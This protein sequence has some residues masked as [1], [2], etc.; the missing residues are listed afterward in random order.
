MRRF[1]FTPRRSARP[2]V[3]PFT[4]FVALAIASPACDDGDSPLAPFSPRPGGA[5]GRPGSDGGGDAGGGEPGGAGGSPAGQGGQGDGDAGAAGQGGGPAGAGGQGGATSAC[6]APSTFAAA[7]ALAPS[8]PLCVTRA[9]AF[10]VPA[11]FSSFSVPAWGRHGGPLA[12]LADENGTTIAFHRWSLP[13]SPTDPAVPAVESATDL[14]LV[15]AAPF[16]WGTAVDLPFGD[17]TLVSYTTGAPNVPGEVLLLDA[18]THAVERRYHANGFFSAFATADGAGGGQLTYMGLS[19]LT[20]EPT[21]VNDSAAY[22]ARACDGGLLGEGCG[23]VR[24]LADS[25][26]SSSPMAA[27]TGG[28]GFFALRAPDGPLE[29]RGF[30]PSGLQA[31]EA[32]AGATFWQLAQFA[33]SLAALAPDGAAAPGYLV[34]DEA[35]DEFGVAQRIGVVAYAPG[36]GGEPV[37]GDVIESALT[38]A[39][40]ATAHVFGAGG[41][42]VWVSVVAGDRG[43]FLALR[44]PP[45]H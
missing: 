22:A 12:L 40:G 33:Q 8:L 21:A 42:D 28:R 44:R 20:A 16:Y 37:K 45:S 7:L 14:G 17:W 5:A 11:G 27:D 26:G 13:A 30:A 39:A 34:V 36:P 6:L 25:T 9:H 38:P 1:P 41:D 18:T 31:A 2:E 24:K 29:L 10:A 19:P 43:H 35:V 23:P 32:G 4:L 15:G 3:A